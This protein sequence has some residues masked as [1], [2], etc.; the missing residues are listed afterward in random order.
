MAKKLH[1][2]LVY[3]RLNL[4]EV[5]VSSRLHSGHDLYGS[6]VVLKLCNDLTLIHFISH[7]LSLISS[8]PFLSFDINK[9]FSAIS[10]KK[11]G[12]KIFDT[13]IE[14]TVGILKRYSDP[15]VIYSS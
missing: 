13:E 4:K 10:G 11:I 2:K 8:H 1:S 15:I 12:K 6:P 7:V 5:S 14:Y 3:E 9:V